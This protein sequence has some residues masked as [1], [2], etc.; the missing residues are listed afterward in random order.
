MGAYYGL[1]IYSRVLSNWHDSS[2]N[3]DHLYFRWLKE[4]A[5]QYLLN[6]FICCEE[7]S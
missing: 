7:Q 2:G 6:I 3:I 1:I 5:Q 4:E